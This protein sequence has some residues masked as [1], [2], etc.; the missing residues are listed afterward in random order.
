MHEDRDRDEPVE[1][2]AEHGA[3]RRGV[4]PPEDGA[5]D[6]PALRAAA[7]RV[8]G[9]A[10]VEVPDVPVHVEGARARSP[11]VVDV[12]AQS[13]KVR[14]LEECRRK[15]EDETYRLLNA[16]SWKSPTALENRPRTDEE[17]EVRHHDHESGQ[18]CRNSWSVISCLARLEDLLARLPNA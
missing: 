7:R 18:C 14:G 1:D 6:E 12:C 3:D 9:V 8:L 11:R 16:F 4:G 13:A 15:E 17:D 5:E 2:V 10:A